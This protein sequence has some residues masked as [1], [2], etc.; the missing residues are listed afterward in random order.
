MQ[1]IQRADV[2]A[3][4]TVLGNCP[5]PLGRF[6]GEALHRDHARRPRTAAELG[7]RLEALGAELGG[8]AG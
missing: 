3:L 8:G 1:R 5:P 7:R 2:P 6:F 4:A